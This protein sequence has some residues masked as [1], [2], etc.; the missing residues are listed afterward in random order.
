M[1][2]KGERMSGLGGSLSRY[3]SWGA[4]DWKFNVLKRCIRSVQALHPF[5][6]IVSEGVMISY[7]VSMPLYSLLPF[8]YVECN[9][10]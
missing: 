10:V 3:S 7:L 4:E 9:V 8:S 5:R 6:S 1:R 2:S